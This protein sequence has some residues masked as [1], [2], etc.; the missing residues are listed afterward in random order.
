MWQMC[1]RVLCFEVLLLAAFV[2]IVAVLAYSLVR[3]YRNM[4]EDSLMMFGI[5]E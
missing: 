2:Y 5:F 3:I 4:H 1:S